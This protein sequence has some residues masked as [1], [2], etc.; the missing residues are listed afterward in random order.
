MITSYKYTELIMLQALFVVT[1]DYLWIFFVLIQKIF[2]CNTV[3]NTY[4]T[5]A[6]SM[7]SI[8]KRCNF[9]NE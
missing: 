6:F 4:Q 1:L 2:L 9:E 5:S 8:T 3:C 7:W